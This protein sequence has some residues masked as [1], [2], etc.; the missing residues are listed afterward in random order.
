M[1]LTIG[2]AFLLT[3]TLGLGL[4]ATTGA[5]GYLLSRNIE[6]N[7]TRMTAISEAMHNHMEGDMMHDA[8]RGD[9]LWAIQASTD[10]EKRVAREE[11]AADQKQ[12]R[13]VLAAV[14][15]VSVDT[16]GIRLARNCRPQVEAYMELA[17]RQVELACTDSAQA[18]Q[19]L[20]KFM[21][22]FN[23]LAGSL[24]AASQTIEKEVAQAKDVQEE[25]ISTFRRTVLALALGSSVLLMGAALLIGRFAV[26]R[27]NASIA[28]LTQTATSTSNSTEQVAASARSVAEGASS[29]AASLEETSSALQ[30]M[31]SMTDRNAQS[32]GQAVELSGQTKAAAENSNQSMSRMSD[33]VSQIQTSASETAKIIRVIDEIAFQTNLLALN[34]AVEA[35]RAGE[36]GK[37]FAVVAEEVR[38]LAMRSAEAAKN[39]AAMIEASVGNARNGVQI[40][41]EVAQTLAKITDASTRTNALVSEIAAASRE[42]AQGIQQVNLAI[43]QMDKV[44][45]SNAASAEQS[46]SATS[47]LAGYSRQL[48]TVVKELA[49]LAGAAC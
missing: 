39:T 17:A 46:A 21:D 38:N 42:Q 25:A 11:V 6:A 20:P 49:A 1:S 45:Q 30:E 32:A 2:K 40:V 35:A 14:D 15:A 10:E 43:A 13:A 23:A 9:V 41:Q 44:T 28:V 12:W 4:L 27:L 29:Q 16:P 18:R 48:H 26:R 8:L 31:T 36:A 37:G 47:E 3:S 22:A 19:A 33:A 34:A 5:V 7:V 24:D